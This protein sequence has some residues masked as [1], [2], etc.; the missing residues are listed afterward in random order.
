MNLRLL[1]AVVLYCLSAFAQ[2]EGPPGAPAWIKQYFDNGTDITHMCVAKHVTGPTTTWLR[3]DATITNIVNAGT[4]ATITFGSPHNLYE[5]AVLV[6]DLWTVDLDLNGTYSIKTTPTSSSAIITT[7]NVGNA[8]YTDATGRIRTPSP[9]YTASVWAIKIY[10]YAVGSYP[11]AS[12]WALGRTE[13][14]NLKCSD[15]AN[16]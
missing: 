2:P 16:Y 11:R 3:S 5:G 15:R 6:L 4:T 10:T 1:A 8:T 9:L 12:Y 14:G 13:P 7:V